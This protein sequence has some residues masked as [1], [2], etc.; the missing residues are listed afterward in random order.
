MTEKK[1]TTK[2]GTAFAGVTPGIRLPKGTTYKTNPDGTLK[3]VP[4][5]KKKS[6]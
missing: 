4:P 2:K 6:K 5:K 3:I 1:K